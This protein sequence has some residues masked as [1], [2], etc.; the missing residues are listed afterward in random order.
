M[1]NA[2]R[3]CGL[4]QPERTRFKERRMGST[5][6]VIVII[7]AAIL[8]CAAFGLALSL[9]TPLPPPAAHRSWSPLGRARGR[10]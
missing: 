8:A 1:A 6:T 9:P 7:V 10:Q 3:C 4:A 5:C 2:R